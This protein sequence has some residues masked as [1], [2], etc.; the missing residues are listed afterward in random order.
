MKRVMPE[1]TQT[2]LRHY[3]LGD[4]INGSPHSVCVS[5]PTMADVIGYEEKDP[6]ICGRIRGGYP[7]F[8]V[9]PFLL[10]ITAVLARK[11]NLKE[12]ALFACCG[13]REAS[14]AAAF[15]G[16]TARA[17]QLD[18]IDIVH[19]PAKDIQTTVNLRQFLQHT[20]TALGSREA[21]HWMSGQGM[22][23][24]AAVEDRVTETEAS[25]AVCSQLASLYHADSPSDIYPARGGMNAFYAAFKAID[26]IQRARG[27]KI[28]I[29]LGWLYLDTMR[30]LQ[31]MGSVQPFALYDVL[32]LECLEHLLQHC[33]TQVA[34]IVTEVPTNPL[35]QTTDIPRLRE[36]ADRYGCALLLDPTI[37]SPH[38]VHILPY[39]DAHINSL[40]KYAGNRGDVMCGA[41]ALNRNSAFYQELKETV[42][43]WLSTPAPMDLARL[44]YQMHDYAATVEAANQNTVKVV[45][46]LSKHPRIQSVGWAQSANVAK[47][48]N[49]IRQENGGPGSMISFR[50]D[51]DWHDFYDRLCMAKTPSF[52][53]YFSVL[54]PFM[55]LA[56]YDQVTTAKGRSELA[57][58]GLSADLLRLSVGMEKADDI[59]GVLQEALS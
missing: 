44:A 38:N 55:Y 26:Q 35:I 8:V 53:M 15:A 43:D 36:L 46:F 45:D 14:A 16:N 24:N 19:C 11:H 20:G 12:Q 34:G 3:P 39:A 1:P 31:K 13:P 10:N 9:H 58:C 22:A 25:Q 52:G 6:N 30:I 21:E 48:Y 5:L 57:A 28:W 17:T 2:T 29:Q 59:C 41:V 7:R 50:V 4:S 42:T 47:H 18:G 51:G 49:T 37:A 27:K 33:G 56:H 40:T 32:D 23:V 54:C